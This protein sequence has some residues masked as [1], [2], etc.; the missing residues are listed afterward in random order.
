MNNDRKTLFKAAIITMSF[1]QTGSS[2]IAPILSQIGEAFPQASATKVQFLMTFPAIFSLVFTIVSALLSDV[3]P[4]K[5][6]ALAGLATVGAGGV[7][8]FLFHGS[9]GIL[10]LWA[11]V[12]GIGI[13]MV[14]PVAPALVNETFIDREKNG[15]KV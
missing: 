2:G 3:F 12:I 14:A 6:L 7:L 4:K 10:F 8:A 9:L 13:G 5:K 15:T 1:V 11:A